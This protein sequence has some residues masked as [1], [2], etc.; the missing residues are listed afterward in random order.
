MKVIKAI[1]TLAVSTHFVLPNDTN[2]QNNLFGGTLMAWMDEIASISAH[3]ASKR[4]VVTANVY[5]IS[6][7]N[8][9]PLGS[10]VTLEAKVSRAF[11]SSM[12]VVVEVFVEDR[13][14]GKKEKS[15]EAIFVFVAIDQNG[16]AIGVPQVE[17]ETESEKRRYASA[18]RRKQ[19]SLV[20]AGR[21]KPSEATE[22]KEIFE[23]REKA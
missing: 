20:L 11:S 12:E 6:F 16:S 3:R 9:I 5:N 4:V 7:S 10:L 18:L 21:M 15:N 22:L 14:S 23:E 13:V 1:D 19:L 2:M 8:P 17:P